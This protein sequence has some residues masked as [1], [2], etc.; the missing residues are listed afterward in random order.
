[1][2]S[3]EEYQRENAIIFTTKYLCILLLNG[4]CTKLSKSNLRLIWVS[5]SVQLDLHLLYHHLQNCMSVI[6][7]SLQ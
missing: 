2:W 7:L 6:I 3:S 5:V 1:M 4:W